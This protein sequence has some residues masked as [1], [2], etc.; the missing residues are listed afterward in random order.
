MKATIQFG[1]LPPSYYTLPVFESKIKPIVRPLTYADF[2]RVIFPDAKTV[3][4][5]DNTKTDYYLTFCANE[6][7]LFEQMSLWNIV[8]T[9]SDIRS[10]NE[11]YFYLLD[12]QELKEISINLE[13]RSFINCTTIKY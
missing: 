3:S 5:K 9:N 7:G 12:H 11:A 10:I 6:A 13:S 2:M 8:L 4:Y 1:E